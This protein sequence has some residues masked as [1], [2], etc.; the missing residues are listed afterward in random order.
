L[1]D[2]GQ[3]VTGLVAASDHAEVEWLF[4]PVA[5]RHAVT[6][7]SPGHRP[8]VDAVVLG[9]F[10]QAGTGQVGLD[11]FELVRLVQPTLVLTLASRPWSPPRRGN[12]K[13]RTQLRQG[14]TSVGVAL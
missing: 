5:T 9:Q 13:K 6:L 2:R 4:E 11:Q 8:L 7:Q 3:Q 10:D 12:I 1:A 14:I